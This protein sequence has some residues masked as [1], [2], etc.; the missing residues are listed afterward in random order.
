MWKESVKLNRTIRTT[1]CTLP[2][3]C[4][5]VTNLNGHGLHLSEIQATKCKCGCLL[6]TFQVKR[7]SYSK[8]NCWVHIQEWA[9]NS[10]SANYSNIS[11]NLKEHTPWNTTTGRNVY[12]YSLMTM[13]R[14]M[15][16]IW[17]HPTQGLP[18]MLAQINLLTPNDDYSGRKAP[19]TSKYFILYIYS[20]NIGT[21]YF[22]HGI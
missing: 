20:T 19:L 1:W 12:C 16:W 5:Y 4:L 14:Q 15:L 17:S 18:R 10:R 8:G 11:V 3:S 6:V 21:E 9:P 7:G 13:I 22:K 2:F